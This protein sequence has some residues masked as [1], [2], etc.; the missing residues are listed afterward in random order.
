MKTT[1]DDGTT[2]ETQ[3]FSSSASAEAWMQTLERANVITGYREE[4]TGK[5]TVKLTIT[6]RPRQTH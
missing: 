6:Y 4:T 1:N 5:R 2:T 3:T